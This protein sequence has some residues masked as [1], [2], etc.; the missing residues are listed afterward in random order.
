MKPNHPVKA[1]VCMK[2]VRIRKISS[3]F[4]FFLIFSQLILAQD[5]IEPGINIVDIEEFIIQMNLNQNHS[6]LDVRTWMEYKKG[7]IPNALFAGTSELM[8]AYTDTMDFDKPLFLYCATNF[9]SKPAGRSLAAKGFKKIYVL[10]PG[11][12]GWRAAG[13]EIDTSR[14]SRVQRKMKKLNILIQ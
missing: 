14:P 9:R 7:R 10:G 4:I 8:T 2:F 6:L 5:E 11:F 1:I 12:Y 3:L 13:K